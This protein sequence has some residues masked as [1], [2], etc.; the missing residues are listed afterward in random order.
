MTCLQGGK[1]YTY[2]G[3]IHIHSTYSDGSS[4]IY[5]IAGEAA[6]AGLSF[7]VITDHETLRGREEEGFIKGVAVLV[8]MEINRLHS[9]YLALNI[10]R[11]IRSNTNNPQEVINKVRRAGGLGIIAHPFEKGS[12]Y[13]E[14]GKAYPWKQWPV[15]GF[16]G[17]EIWNYSSHWRGLHPS[18]F[19]TIYWFFFNRPAAMKGP[20][21]EVLQLWDCYNL[22]GHR[23]VAVG[24]SDAHATK[25][26]LGPIPITLFTYSYIF[27]TI[28]TY[29]VTAAR[30]STDYDLA[31]EQ[32]L[33]ALRSG[34]CYISFDSLNPGGGFSFQAASRE[35][36]Y[37]M[38]E[39]AVLEKG[40]TLS[41]K[42]PPGRPHIR[43]IHNGSVIVLENT[44]VL[45]YYVT[46]PGIYR[47]ELY[48][49]PLIG[50][51]RPWIYSN[52]IYINP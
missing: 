16:N 9:H 32:I 46:E 37:S 17:L 25:Y 36:V 2:P 28:N 3:N 45:E 49:R 43:L 52:P 13:I 30:L 20:S 48:H 1:M 38:G 19:K 10:Q 39:S 51:P 4:N 27:S 21:H 41:I 18:L 11:E 42:S 29:I 34:S 8:G 24:G 14:K 35:K 26:K 22:N 7:V 44:A 47:V 33:S 12:R 5:S 6:K 15:F 40:L 50:Q 31:A 23:I